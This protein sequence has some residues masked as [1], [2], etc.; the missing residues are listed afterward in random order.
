MSLGK[1][2]HY[3]SSVKIALKILLIIACLSVIH[4]RELA[5]HIRNVQDFYVFNDDVR[6]YIPPFYRYQDDGPSSEDY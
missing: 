6:Q 4:H 5:E 2:L 1:W 3:S